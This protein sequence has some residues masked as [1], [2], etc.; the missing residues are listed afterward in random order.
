MAAVLTVWEVPSEL[1]VSPRLVYDMVRR[2][3]LHGIR[4]GRLIR[5]PEAALEDH[6]HIEKPLGRTPGR[7]PWQ[8]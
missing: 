7:W 5:I 1:K 3:E 2:G 8:P 6:L 4:A